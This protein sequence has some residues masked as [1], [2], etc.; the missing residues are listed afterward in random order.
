MRKL[1]VYTRKMKQNTLTRKM[2]IVMNMLTYACPFV[3][4]SPSWL[5]PGS[6]LSA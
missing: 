6:K 2:P 1:F 4:P 5:K 3:V